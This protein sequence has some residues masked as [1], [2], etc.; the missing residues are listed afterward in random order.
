L[1]VASFHSTANS[2][3]ELLSDPKLV[4]SAD[5]LRDLSKILGPYDDKSIS[6]FLKMVSALDLASTN[7]SGPR[8]GDVVPAIAGMCRLFELSLKKKEIDELKQLL[9]LL[10]RHESVSLAQLSD[11]ISS[12]LESLSRPKQAAPPNSALVEDYHIRLAKA[13]GNDLAFMPLYEE[14]KEDKKRM[15]KAEMASL[16]DLF[17]GP[18]KPTTT[19][20]KALEKILS[21][22]RKL[23]EF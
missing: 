2:F 18:V 17:M 4:S 11:A 15:K 5:A 20:P 7:G 1:K 22:H 21:R 3:A 9:A 19:R 6:Q 23:V 16:A 10:M 13:L 12:H 14:L 8:V